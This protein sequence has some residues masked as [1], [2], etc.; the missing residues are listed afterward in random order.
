MQTHLC[1]EQPSQTD[2]YRDFYARRTRLRWLL[3]FDV[4]YRCRRLHDVL[5]RLG[6]DTEWRSV[7]DVGFG[8]GH[9]LKSFPTTC[10]LVGADI[11]ESA[12]RGARQSNAYGEWAGAHFALADERDPDRLPPGKFDIIVSSH[13]LEHV[14]DDAAVLAALRAR[15]VSGGV[16]CVF[17]PVE[18]TGYNP[19]HVREYSVDSI[20]ERIASCGF[21]VLYAEGS[22]SLNGHLWKTLTVPSRH[23]WPVL[24]PIVD[25][26]RGTALSLVPYRAH[27]AFDELI[28]C[29]AL[30]PRQALVVARNECR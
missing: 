15:L 28:G 9:L 6:I 7:L 23:R 22:L 4:R 30:G 1:A 19:D 24:G 5:S 20:R 13:T 11:S 14:P 17:V 2:R 21:D 27:V 26:L 16:L 10:S 3:R 29:T 18:E 8:S 12:V 25:V